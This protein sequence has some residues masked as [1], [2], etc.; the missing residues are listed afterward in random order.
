MPSRRHMRQTV[1]LTC[2]TCF[3]SRPGV[4]ADK[5]RLLPRAAFGPASRWLVAVR[6]AC[7]SWAAA[8]VAQ[9]GDV[10]IDLIFSPALAGR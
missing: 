1:P 4:R 6:R 10:L 8:V 7:A 5:E 9:G 2:H 3:N